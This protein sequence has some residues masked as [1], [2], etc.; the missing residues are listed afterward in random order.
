HNTAGDAGDDVK[1]P[2]LRRVL[3][4]FQQLE[5]TVAQFDEFEESR[6]HR[7]P[8]VCLDKVPEV[9]VELLQGMRPHV[10]PSGV[11]REMRGFACGRRDG[12]RCGHA[13]ISRSQHRRWTTS[14]EI[15]SPEE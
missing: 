6:V 9:G 7:T 1:V 8:G 10:C 11:L 14:R 12:F 5:G 4:P 15:W 2:A 13:R 3:S